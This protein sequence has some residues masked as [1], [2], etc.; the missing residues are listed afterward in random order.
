MNKRILIFCTVLS[1]FGLS[2]FGL[3]AF[4]LSAFGLS[5]FGLSAFGYQN[6]GHA[7]TAQAAATCSKPVAPTQQESMYY[8]PLIDAE[9]ALNDPYELTYTVVQTGAN[10]YKLVTN[11]QLFGGS[12]YVSPHATADFKG[13][14]TIKMDD[15]DHLKMGADFL[16]IPRSK[17]V[18]DP[19][20]FV[21]GPVNWVQEDTQY[22]HQLT[23]TFSEDFEVRGKFVFTI[24]PKCTLEQI[25]FVIKF[26]SGVL[27]IE[28]W[29]C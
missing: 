9:I 6:W 26:K 16:E 5:A 11:M 22:E 28:K 24:E 20:P 3:S 12:F 8:S 29:M 17:E 10:Q 19:H 25:P 1:A 7:A 2:A 21:N 13:K 14:F 23:V 4:G 15:N 18:F 27:R